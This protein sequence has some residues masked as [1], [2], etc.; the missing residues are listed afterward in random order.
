[1]T[2]RL[3]L[4]ASGLLA[5]GCSGANREG[6]AEAARDTG[7]ESVTVVADCPPAAVPASTEVNVETDV[8]YAGPV[9]ESNGSDDT[10]QF[11]IAWPKDG[12]RH[13]LVVLLHGGGWEGGSKLV[14]RDEMLALAGQGYAAASVAYRL[15]REGRNIFPAPVEDVRCA[16]R[17]LRARADAYGIDRARVAALG[18]S[19]GAH[20]ASMLG[21][22][23]NEGR[24][25]RACTAPSEHSAAV[26][27]VVSYAGPQDLRVHG[28]YTQ[29]QARLVT[30]FLG[31]FPG[32]AP[33]IAAAASPI[34][35]VSRG[36]APFLFVHGTRDELV[37]VDHSRWMA[38]TLRQSGVPAT[39][40][41]LRG[42]RHGFVSLTARGRPRVGCT[43]LA[44]LDRWLRGERR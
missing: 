28:P 30:N 7:G 1:V 2:R 20:L 41:E 23:G 8:A 5:C 19:A 44:F 13:P 16:V 21:V 12:G 31:V 43:V 24:F 6:P 15:T 34:T 4:V 26:S 14:M 37:P 36:D 33:A 35:H 18:F 9:D 42:M 38:A 25:D 11:D 22:T 32:D 27:A 3:R 29:E 17:A 10:L 39:V 40:I